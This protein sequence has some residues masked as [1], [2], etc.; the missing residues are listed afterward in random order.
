M[1]IHFYGTGAS[2]GVPAMFC[3][4]EC[5]Q[6]LRKL[7]GK[8][9]RT[10]SGAQV[11]DEIL[12]DFSADTYA[13]ELYGGL[14]IT[15]INYLFITHSHIDHL[16]APDLLTIRPPMAF[17]KRKRELQ[18][19]GNDKAISKI[20]KELEGYGRSSAAEYLK[21]HAIK[22]FEKFQA[23]NYQVTALPANHD[24]NEDCLLYVITHNGKTLLYGHDS[25]MFGEDCWKS[26]KEF[27]FDCVVLD[28]TMV[29]ETGI[30]K[31][32]MGLPDNVIIRERM[33]KE[34]MA[35]KH[36][37]FFATHFVHTYD[38]EHGR[39]TPI[40]KEKGLIAAYDGLEEE[41]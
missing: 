28:C 13:H 29:E 35:T 26:M 24:K 36:T 37:K 20:Q 19:F 18:V 5:C 10:R 34:N 4:C 12:I 11:D 27:H 40:F 41:F 22:P 30:F 15:A 32:H 9:L 6:K 31:E 25:A 14:D 21:L 38:P 17:Y 8:N 1:K 16:Y 33:L 7:G 39:I 2:E 23:G 3:E